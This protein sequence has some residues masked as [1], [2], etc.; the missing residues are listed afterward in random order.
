MP[1][2]EPISQFPVSND[3]VSSN[4][5]VRPLR[6][7]T[8][9]KT[10]T[11]TS[12]STIQVRAVPSGELLHEEPNPH[13]ADP[14]PNPPAGLP[15]G[16]KVLG[17]SED[18]KWA[19]LAPAAPT[20]AN[21]DLTLW[22][23]T[24]GKPVRELNGVSL[25][26]PDYVRVSSDGRRMAYI[27]TET[28]QAI[29]VYDWDAGRYLSLLPIGTRGAPET[30][31][32]H[33]GFSPDSS[34]LAFNGRLNKMYG[35]LLY[36]VGTGESAGIFDNA[37]IVNSAWSRDGRW[38]IT[39]GTAANGLNRQPGSFQHT[40][41]HFSEVI[42][43]TPTYATAGTWGYTI[44]FVRDGGAL[45]AGQ[46]FYEV[47]PGEKRTTLKPLVTQKPF[48][49]AGRVLPVA[50]GAWLLKGGDDGVFT[51]QPLG[52]GQP[53]QTFRHPGFTDET[54]R[55]D[56]KMPVGI[57]GRAELSPDATR[58]LGLFY[59]D[60]GDAAAGAPGSERWSL[61][62]WDR[63]RG[64]RLAV[65]NAGGY[66][67]G[68]VSLRFTP[69]GKRA[70]TLSTRGLTVWDVATGKP[71]RTIAEDQSYPLRGAG[72]TVQHEAGCEQLD[73][74]ADGSRFVWLHGDVMSGGR[75]V[76]RDQVTLHDT[77][78]GKKLRG[79]S[80]GNFHCWPA[81][82]AISPDGG[83]VAMTGQ[84]SIKLLDAADGKT[85]VEWDAHDGMITGLAF[86]PD[87]TALVSGDMGGTVKVWHL[88]WIRRE[89]KALWLDW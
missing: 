1:G 50:D 82:A 54:L 37:V 78:T 26:L 70:L 60:Y 77:A 57:L 24:T 36:D 58:L 86:S 15:A 9:G 63:E 66:D 19:V 20:D 81:A 21:R 73:I 28:A 80:A 89:L 4:L 2:V 72:R 52:D 71:E 48:A 84:S 49:L 42:Y 74:V 35:L 25:P 47:Q 68:F 11:I 22:D 65:W 38:L 34:L 75:V 40:Y 69:D 43:P 18:A 55:Q 44:R 8:D 7:S 61:E 39:A 17:A 29:K 76:S 88:A 62:L 14:Q 13:V 27:D 51:L 46:N 56:G 5:D 67:E 53:P 16:M 83:C 85:L 33:A 31:R 30:L 87:G 64:Q 59:L 79:W 32:N 45:I 10:V 12:P 3:L 6:V 41:L 23:A